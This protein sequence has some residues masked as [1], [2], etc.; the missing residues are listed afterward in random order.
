MYAALNASYSDPSTLNAYSL[1]IDHRLRDKLTLFGRYDYSPSQILLRGNGGY[2]LNTVFSNQI[3]TQTATLGATWIVS[4][5]LSNDLRFNYSRTDASSHYTMDNF[6]GAVPL[7][8]APF[9]SPYTNQNA[10]FQFFILALTNSVITDGANGH[11]V[12]RQINLVDSLSAQRGSHSLKFGFDF[13][14]LTPLFD[15]AL[16]LQEPLFSDVPSAETG[17]PFESVV[18][19][20]RSATFLFR[21]LGVYAQDTWRVNPRLTLTYGLRWDVNFVPQ[22]VNG[23]SFPAVTG[24]NLGNLSNLALAPAGTPPY[25]T[26]YGNFAPRL[27][28]AYQLRQ[29][30][31]WQSVLRGGGGVFYD[32]ATSEIGN[33]IAGGY[34]FGASVFPLGGAFPLN[35]AT[36][37]PPP[38]TPPNATN[39]GVLEALDPHLKL[40]YTLEWNVALEQALGTQ[41]TITASYIGAS[42][43]RLLQTAVISSPNPN[44]A[45]AIL[46]PNAG[47]SDYNA[48][49]L[50]FQRR[51]SHGLQTLASYTWSHSIDTASA[52]STLVSSNALVPSAIN[53]NRG[54]SDFDIRHAFSAGLTYDIPAPRISGFVNV[55]LRGWSFENVIQARSAP[56]VDIFDNN[57]FELFGGVIADVRPDLVPGQPLYLYGSQCPQAPPLGFGQSCPGGKGFNPNAF[58][59]PPSDPITGLPLR[60]G[61]VPR[62]FLRGFGATQWDLAVHRDFPIIESV[63]LQFRAEMFN[64]LNHPNFGQPSGCFGICTQPFG[65]SNQ[66]L[67]QYLNGGSTGTSNLGG[68]AFSPLYQLGG[69]RSVQ[70]ALKLSF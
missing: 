9:P 58:S 28:V 26:T 15:P 52:G 8:S 20:S 67:G 27:G 54:S 5:A 50:Q 12:Q 69:P 42:G 29:S 31:D 65:L 35:A 57:F 49:Q 7:A 6:G 30:Q 66:T 39:R 53:A 32:L 43:R 19:S 68:G 60:Q 14:R 23:P 37:A 36:A 48:L 47:A 11:Q 34:P 13:R 16:Y 22:S 70:F 61:N 2:S 59:N 1:R 25:R 38:I 24:F 40:P 63:K 45:T 18:S 17:S 10:N 62:N 3:T 41:Q 44:L 55:I 46:V 33:G 56:P 64:L 21:D 4:P 51:L